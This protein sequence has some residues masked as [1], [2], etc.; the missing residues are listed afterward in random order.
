MPP[1]EVLYYQD[2][3]GTVPIKEW[4]DGLGAEPR[5]RCVVRLD[6]LQE[7][8]SGLRRP[9]AENI[10]G[11]LYELRVRV[12]RVNLRMLYFFHGRAAAVVSHGFSKERKIPPREIAAAL[13]RMRKFREDPGRHTFTPE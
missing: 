9:I 7:H 6:M 10:G 3:D 1:I 2:D 5:A 12:G 4:L 11:G 13:G 8:G